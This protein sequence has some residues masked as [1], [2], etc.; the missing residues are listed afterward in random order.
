MPNPRMAMLTGY[1][2]Q[3]ARKGSCRVGAIMVVILVASVLYGRSALSAQHI[4]P[5]HLKLTVP[6]YVIPGEPELVT[7]QKMNPA[8]AVVILN[9]DN[10]DGPFNSQWQSQADRLRARGIMVLGYVHTD[11]GTRPIAD[12]EAS[13]SNYLQSS[14]GGKPHVSGIFLDEIPSTCWPL[15][16][17]AS[18]YAFIQHADPGAFVVAN[19]GAP[20]SA[21]Y[22]RSR[23]TI[24]QTF[25]T[26]EHDAVTYMSS[27]QGNVAEPN[28]RFSA[29]KQ[30][31]A[32]KFW[33]MIYAASSSQL[34]HIVALVAARHAGWAYITDANL[35][36]PYDT[37]PGY[38]TAE[39]RTMAA[40][41][42]R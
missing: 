34:P 5:A 29:G 11:G 6:A 32:T 15:S 3:A 26:F 36:N 27:Y 10:G 28:G 13:I 4:V 23:R 39:A 1:V 18:L 31:P 12:T 7:L 16:Y 42:T 38:I 24:A 21:C 9:P 37:L 40:T 25:V 35:P 19:P 14:S 8:P 33:H 22:L 2:R 17:Y 20:V 30:Y 41:S